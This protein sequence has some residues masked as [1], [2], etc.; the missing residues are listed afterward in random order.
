MGTCPHRP[1]QEEGGKP[2]DTGW[3]PTPVACPQLLPLGRHS[4]GALREPSHLL[5]QTA[6]LH[7]HVR[8]EQGLGAGYGMLLRLAQQQAPAGAGKASKMLVGGGKAGSEQGWGV[9]MGNA[10]HWG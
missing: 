5:A 9:R 10:T 1:C 3:A 2:W 8:A 7:G 6:V 4:P